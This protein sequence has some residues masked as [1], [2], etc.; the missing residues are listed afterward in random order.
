MSELLGNIGA[1]V[2]R[3]EPR[4]FAGNLDT[5]LNRAAARIAA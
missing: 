3:F 4:Q 2:S 1:C 5:L